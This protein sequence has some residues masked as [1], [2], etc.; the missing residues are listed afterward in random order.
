MPSDGTTPTPMVDSGP[1]PVVLPPITCD[2][3]APQRCRALGEAA[4]AAID[5]PTLSAPTTIDV[6]ASLLCGDNLDCPI[7][8][9]AGH[10]PAGSAII[11]YAGDA[12]V[13]VNIVEPDI[14]PAANQRHHALDAWVIRSPGG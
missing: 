7:D 5:D 10:H 12:T 8:R 13:W 2:N 6:S 14:P 4:I 11:S 9:L 3:V 1:A